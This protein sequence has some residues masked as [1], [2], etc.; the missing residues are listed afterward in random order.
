[1]LIAFFA[2]F[3]AFDIEECKGCKECNDYWWVHF[4]PSLEEVL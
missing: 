2:S 3:T 4:K 1:M